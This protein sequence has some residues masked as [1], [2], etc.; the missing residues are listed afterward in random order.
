MESL[1]ELYKI[2]FGPSSSHTMGPAIAANIF[3]NKHPEIHDFKVDLYGSLALTGKGHLTDA[4]IYQMFQGKNVEVK[5][6]YL[7]SFDYHPNGMKFSAV[8]NGEVIDE[9]L[10]FSVGGGSIRELN[11]ERKSK[12]DVYP[13]KNFADIL[14]YCEENELTL[15]EYI[16]K[17]EPD[18]YDYLNKVYD[19]MVKS[20]NDGLTTKTVLPGRL[21]LERKAQDFHD[22]YLLDNRLRSLVFS[23]TLAVAEQN[24]SGNEIVTAPTCGSSGVVPGVVIAYHKHKGISKQKALDALAIA[25][26]IGNVVKENAS[27]SG[28]EVGC[29]GEIG[30]ACSMAAGALAYLQGGNNQFIEY[31]AE[32]ALE[33]HL[34]MTCDPVD[35]LVQIP[36][37]ER[38]AVAAMRAINAVSLA[39]FLTHTRKI[40]FDMVIDTMYE[41][42]IDLNHT[43]KET[44]KGGLARKYRVGKI[45]GIFRRSKNRNK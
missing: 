37:I 29:Q 19:V 25:G 6:N 1:K 10:V 13:H 27:I 9:W 32:I 40:S 4:I 42:G 12:V 16:L 26:L 36:C 21:R 38:N 43:Y 39:N 8:K 3:K 17:F 33:H 34:G 5:F 30:V 22:R 14:K 7:E 35:G 18:I 11:E 20:I 28:A 24:A 23:Y 31:S 44:S 2:G 15:V 41:T 45:L